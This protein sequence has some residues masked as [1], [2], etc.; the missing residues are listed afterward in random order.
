MY[1]ITYSILSIILFNIYSLYLETYFM[2]V[3]Y[4]IAISY[5]AIALYVIQVSSLLGNDDYMSVLSMLL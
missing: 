1:V 4:K 2:Y 3:S 5:N